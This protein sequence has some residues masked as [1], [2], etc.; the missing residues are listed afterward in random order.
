MMTYFGDEKILFIV[1]GLPMYMTEWIAN[2]FSDKHPEISI[3]EGEE[4]EPLT[5]EVDGDIINCTCEDEDDVCPA[6]EDFFRS[7]L[8]D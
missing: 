4:V 6:C 7:L 1:D 3:V 5:L 2:E 8:D